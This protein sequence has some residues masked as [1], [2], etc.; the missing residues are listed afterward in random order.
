[1]LRQVE[2]AASVELFTDTSTLPLSIAQVNSTVYVEAEHAP[3]PAKREA[4][5]L[6]AMHEQL[7]AAVVTRVGEVEAA[8]WALDQAKAACN[9]QMAAA[10]SSGVPAE[11]V[12][13]AAGVCASA[14][15]E[16]TGGRKPAADG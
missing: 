12:A 14:L 2:K 11:K 10:L 15:A 3:A 4:G 5:D 1:L 8:E 9:E 6:F 7:L 13:V 16:F